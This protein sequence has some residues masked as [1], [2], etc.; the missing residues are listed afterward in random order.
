[1]IR[2]QKL[3]KKLKISRKLNFFLKKIK[4]ST[5][6]NFLIKFA[7]VPA[8]STITEVFYLK[9]LNITFFNK[10]QFIKKT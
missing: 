6:L 1:M 4:I 2:K 9:L 8:F 5:K 3:K 10:N 7:S